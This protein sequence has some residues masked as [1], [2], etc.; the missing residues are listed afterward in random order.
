MATSRLAERNQSEVNGISVKRGAPAGAGANR[1]FEQ[2]A[3]E[4]EGSGQLSMVSEYSTGF[5]EGSPAPVMAADAAGAAGTSVKERD[6]V[7]HRADEGHDASAGGSDTGPGGSDTGRGRS[8]P[9]R[10][11]QS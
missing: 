7:G 9:R 1:P 6:D 4:S 5:G 11:A 3:M 10:K 2:D 8:E